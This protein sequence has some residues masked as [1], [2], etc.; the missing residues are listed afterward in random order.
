MATGTNA[1][2]TE[3]EIYNLYKTGS[4]DTNGKCCTK[5]RAITLGV[6]SSLLTSYANNQLVKYKDCLKT[7]TMN[8]NFNLRIVFQVDAARMKQYYSD[9]YF[10]V[11][12]NYYENGQTSYKETR[13]NVRTQYIASSGSCYAGNA[14]IGNPW[15]YNYQPYDYIGVTNIPLS[16]SYGG[17]NS[18][19]TIITHP[20]SNIQVANDITYTAGTYTNASINLTI[21]LYGTNTSGSSNG[22]TGGTLIKQLSSTDAI[23]GTG[24]T[25]QAAVS[26]SNSGSYNGPY[27]I[28]VANVEKYI[29]VFENSTVK[30]NLSSYDLSC[31]NLS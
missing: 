3:Q 30:S 31:V 15:V 14:F 29:I 24:T 23:V 6:D 5:S 4:P 21:S 18:S 12:L 1:I 17:I 25:L 10:L 7:Y 9:L 22:T 26:A 8:P 11:G 27:N 13:L 20:G 19:G 2:A 16:V 28:S